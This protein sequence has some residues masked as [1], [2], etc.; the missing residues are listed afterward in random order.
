MLIG[1]IIL[2]ISFLFLLRRMYKQK[3]MTPSVFIIFIYTLSFVS[4]CVLIFCGFVHE[5]PKIDDYLSGFLFLLLALSLYL[6]PFVN[7]DDHRFRTMKIPNMTYLRKF[8]IILTLGSFF[9]LIFYIPVAYKMLTLSVL[10]IGAMR[11]LINAGEHPFIQAGTLNALAKL[12]A[13]LYNIQLVFFFINIIVEKKIRSFSWLILLSSLS[14]VVY[15]LAFM[16]RDGFVFWLFSFVFTYL[17]FYNFISKAI[18]V[19]LKKLF[20]IVT[21]SFG[22]VFLSITIGRFVVGNDDNNALIETLLSYMGQGSINFAEYFSIPNM[23]TDGGKSLFLPLFQDVDISYALK[24]ESLLSNYDIVPWIF[25][26]FI[27]SIYSSLGSWFTILLGIFLI[28]IYRNTFKERKKGVLSFSFALIYMSVF[29]VYSQGVFYLTYYHNIAHLSLL[30]IAV[31]ALYA[32]SLPC[33]T[34][35]C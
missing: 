16:G 11:A 34:I 2:T 28:I 4:S 6:Y 14:Y 27:V 12:F 13:F 26:T 1:V 25:K 10:D 22:F 21:I 7:V 3:G 30:L 9:S 15:V 29:T 5:N 24:R 33:V 8:V 35:K 31:L 19:R 17:L 20:L 32:R 18:A 23:P